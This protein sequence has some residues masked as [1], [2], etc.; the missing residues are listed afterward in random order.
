M[1]FE[2][3][4][5][6]I[7]FPR[8]QCL[9]G[10]HS[11]RCWWLFLEAGCQG[12]IIITLLESH[13]ISEMKGP[14]RSCSRGTCSVLSNLALFSSLNQKAL[15]SSHSAE[16]HGKGVVHGTHFEELVEKVMKTN[17]QMKICR[18]S[19]AGD[20]VLPSRGAVRVPAPHLGPRA[21]CQLSD[22]RHPPLSLDLNVPGTLGKQNELW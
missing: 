18:L 17:K 16:S 21:L 19:V 15:S 12:L 20:L 13:R 2:N 3:S 4:T 7:A 6:K 14:E 5:R 9:E 8:Q 10:R 11:L 1:L 22:T